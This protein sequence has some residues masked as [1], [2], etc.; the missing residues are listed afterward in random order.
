M[1]SAIP[2]RSNFISLII[3]PCF[4]VGLLSGSAFG[5]DSSI[6]HSGLSGNS[7]L[8]LTQKSSESSSSAVVQSQS[9]KHLESASAQVNN[10][11]GKSC[12]TE[13]CSSAAA[14]SYNA[15]KNQS[16]PSN[17]S[18]D[19]AKQSDGLPT[20][21]NIEMSKKLNPEA[22][23]RGFYVFA[24][25]TFIVMIYV[26]WRSFRKR[27]TQIHRYGVVANREDLEMAP[28]DSDDADDDDTTHFDISKHRLQ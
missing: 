12:L 21:P 20:D 15:S 1:S 10:T 24:G 25:L 17:V 3:I 13:P 18:M 19:T 2:L 11:A 9:S 26:A 27:P 8:S 5:T 6:G 4:A 16:L 22:L 7:S 14:G 23:M 28:L